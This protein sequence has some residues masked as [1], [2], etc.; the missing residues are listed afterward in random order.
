MQAVAAVESLGTELFG[1]LAVEALMLSSSWRVV[2]QAQIIVCPSVRC[3]LWFALPAP[4]CRGGLC[5]VHS[6]AWYRAEIGL[7][8]LMFGEWLLL[9]PE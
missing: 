2:A 7:R 8:V 5:H 3:L 4:L 6:H 1:E 9:S